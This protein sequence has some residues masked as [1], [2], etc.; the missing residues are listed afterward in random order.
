VMRVFATSECKLHQL[1]A[2]GWSGYVGRYNSRGDGHSLLVLIDALVAAHC[3]PLRH[4][5]GQI[6]TGLT[7][8][9][10]SCRVGVFPQVALLR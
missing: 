9:T 2:G 1:A 8:Y 3:G 7:L 5:C 4:L 10:P 6:D